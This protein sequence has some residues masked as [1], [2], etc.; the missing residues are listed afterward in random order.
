MVP[1]LGLNTMPSVQ[2]L[3]DTKDIKTRHIKHIGQ[4]FT[5]GLILS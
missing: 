1:L 4:A 2:R 3:T 5:Q